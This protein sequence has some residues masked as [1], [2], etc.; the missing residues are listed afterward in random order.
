M[1]ISDTRRLGRESFERKRWTEAYARLSEA[2]RAAP[3][4]PNDLE[5]LATAAYLI[6]KDSESAAAWGRAHQEYLRRDATRDV[7]Y[8]TQL[9]SAHPASPASDP[10]EPA[11]APTVSFHTCSSACRKTE[12]ACAP[13]TP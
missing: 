13:L 12:V 9:P 8:E 3:L 5:R 1:A 2:E 6:G 10:I 11:P 4:G 7:R